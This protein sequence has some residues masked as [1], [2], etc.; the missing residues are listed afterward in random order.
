MRK[1]LAI[2]LLAPVTAWGAVVINWDPN[3]S[4]EGVLDYQV[5]IDATSTYITGDTQAL[6]ADVLP[7]VD[8]L[9]GS[10]HQAD[11]RARNAYGWG[12]WS[13]SVLFGPPSAPTYVF[14][15]SE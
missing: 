5:R 10:P 12:P 9:D 4:G 1:L 6:C 7:E 15:I 11:V 8:C 13:A 14:V 2:L 3:P